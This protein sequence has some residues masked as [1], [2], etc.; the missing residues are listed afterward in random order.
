M[1]IL[2]LLLSIFFS[3]QISSTDLHLVINSHNDLAWGLNMNQ[4]YNGSNGGYW[5]WVCVKCI[6][7]E[8]IV[9]F[10]K[11]F[12]KIYSYRDVFCS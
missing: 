8:L 7:E 3:P 4:I 12:E 11:Q 5:S 10:R 2:V 1:I 6:F 9:A